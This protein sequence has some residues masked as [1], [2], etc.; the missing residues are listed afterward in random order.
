MYAH[1]KRGPVSL[2]LSDCVIHHRNPVRSSLRWKL[3]F[4]GRTHHIALHCTLSRL[5]QTTPAPAV[6]VYS[7]TQTTQ[8]RTALHCTAPPRR[9]QSREQSAPGRGRRLE[10]CRPGQPPLH[11][12]DVWGSDDKQ[13]PRGRGPPREPRGSCSTLGCRQL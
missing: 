11:E 10:H 8:H 1:S 4:F 13:R 5:G 9:A 12:S 3:R 2:L 6:V 7:L